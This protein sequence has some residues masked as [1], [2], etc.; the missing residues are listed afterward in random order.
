MQNTKLQEQDLEV[1]QITSHKNTTIARLCP[2]ISLLLKFVTGA[3]GMVQPSPNDDVMY[4]FFG[5]QSVHQK[6]TL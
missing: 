5:L 6:V 1:R 2:D 4:G 3:L